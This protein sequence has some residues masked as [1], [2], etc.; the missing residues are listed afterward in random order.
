[1][2]EEETHPL[3][4]VALWALGASIAV[5]GALWLTGEVS[6]RIFGGAWP[7]VQL[8]E[9]GRVLARFHGH[10]ANPAQAWPPSTRHLMPGA[11]AFYGTLAAVLAPLLGAALFVACRRTSPR[12]TGARWA[13]R[14]DLRALRIREPQPG[15][16]TL[17]RVDGRLVA[18][19]ARQSVIVIGPVQTGKTSGF[20]VPAILEWRGPVV[21]TSVKTDLLRETFVA[22]GALAHANVWVY[23]P[24]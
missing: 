8:A 13:R 10:A 23:D 12:R 15:R 17:G 20:A 14:R 3:E 21:A 6:G 19:E 18:A 9:M 4:T 1:M 16:L 5:G 2:G 11:V 7:H 24:T 22:R